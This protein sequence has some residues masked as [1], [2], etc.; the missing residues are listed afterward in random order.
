VVFLNR[1][2]RVAINGFGRIG[3]AVFKIAL[4]KSNIE[5][6]A[7][8]DLMEPQVL[9]HLLTYDSVY[10]RFKHKVDFDKANIIIK[11]KKFPIYAAK[12]PAK[13]P[14]ND[15]KIDVVL[16]CT[17]RFT[18]DGAARAHVKAG[19]K[20]VIVS[21]PTKGGDVGTFLLGVNSK[22][23]E[24]QD[25][26]SNA[27]CTTNCVAPVAFVL[28]RNFGIV[29]GMVTTVHAYTA[30]QN[31]V[32]GP[33]PALHKD[34][35]RARA[36]GINIVP[37]STGAATATAEVIPGLSGAF[38]GM[39]LRVPVAI[40]SLSD[41]TVLLK[42]PASAEE[43]NR[44]FRNYASEHPTILEVTDA[45]IVSSDIVGNTHSAIV[46]AALTKVIGGNFAKVVAW[47][48]NEWGYANRLVE[49]IFLVSR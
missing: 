14:W 31:L 26:I 28:A 10:G 1:K 37:T 44:A 13:L 17:G 18:K 21:A 24:R 30:E 8:N 20:R 47:Y 15:Q 19:A 12:D 43:I 27:S 36:A 11:N 42:N 2:I 4:D 38:D 25:V 22:E 6:A 7:I 41:F 3:R 9:A 40:G 16:E 29:K 49:E 33:P 39:A 32:D 34:L 46:D 23:Y 48:D 5:I 35:R 45:P